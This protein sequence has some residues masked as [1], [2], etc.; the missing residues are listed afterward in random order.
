[1]KMGVRRKGGR[2]GSHIWDRGKGIKMIRKSIYAAL[3]CGSA[4][5]IS[6][7]AFAQELPAALTKLVG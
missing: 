1:M 2:H 5:A 6:G 4:F 3:L 7:G